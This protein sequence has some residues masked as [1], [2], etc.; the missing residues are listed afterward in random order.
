MIKNDQDVR[1][2]NMEIRYIDSQLRMLTRTSVLSEWITV[3][4]VGKG[5]RNGFISEWIR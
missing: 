4:T 3:D 5:S 2:M 1:E